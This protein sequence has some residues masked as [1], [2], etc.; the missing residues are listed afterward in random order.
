MDI[1]ALLP[2]VKAAARES[3]HRILTMYDSGHY[4]AEQK[5]DDSPVTSA[6]LAAHAYL[7]KALRELADVPVLS[8]EGGDI[9]LAERGRW[10]RYWLVDPLDGTQEF[11]AGSG[12]FS[13]MIALI[14]DGRPVLGV[15][16]APVQDLMYYAVRGHGAFKEADGHHRRIHARHHDAAVPLTQLRIAI[17]RRQNVDWVRSRLNSELDYEMVPLGSSSLK[18]CLVAEGEADL[19]IR[20][21]PTGEWDTGATQCIVEEAGGR[22][23]DLNLAALSYNR[24]DS[25]VN[26][27]FITLGDE[28]LP[29]QQILVSV[30]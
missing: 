28:G 1:H 7:D 29:W 4:Q 19:Y 5:D 20:I 17:S 6:D 8:E 18:S 14:E 16:Y 22:L 21:G 11:I 10:P 3:G 12:D 27:N 13:T 30:G 25:M 23:L 2:G 24:R 9:P 15:V 26:P